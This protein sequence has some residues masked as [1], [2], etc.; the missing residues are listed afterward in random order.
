MNS[1]LVRLGLVFGGFCPRVIWARRWWRFGLIYYYFFSNFSPS[2]IKT[3][4]LGFYQGS[5]HELVGY[6]VPDDS[7]SLLI[8]WRRL[9]CSPW[10]FSNGAGGGPGSVWRHSITECVTIKLKPNGW[11]SRW[12]SSSTQSKVPARTSG[13]SPPPPFDQF[14]LIE[15]KQK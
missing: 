9:S 15:S 14:Q 3:F 1:V 6:F 5:G 12:I 10:P 13:I 4:I 2:F 8:W 11:Q 7:M